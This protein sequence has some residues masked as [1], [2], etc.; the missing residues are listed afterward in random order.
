[1]DEPQT[2]RILGGPFDGGGT[3]ELEAMAPARIGLPV[4]P[5][6]AACY[7][8]AWHV[9]HEALGTMEWVGNEVRTR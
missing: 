7:T 9:V 5:V 2:L 8:L 1:M 4:G 6:R 3:H